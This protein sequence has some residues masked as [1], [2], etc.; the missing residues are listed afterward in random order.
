[1]GEGVEGDHRW[2]PVNADLNPGLISDHGCDIIFAT[3]LV[4]DRE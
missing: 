2:C 1:M 3:E 4:S